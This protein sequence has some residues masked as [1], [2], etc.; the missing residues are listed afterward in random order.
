MKLTA[1]LK[2]SI[3]NNKFVYALLKKP[4]QYRFKKKTQ[5]KREAIQQYGLECLVLVKESFQKHQKEFWLDYGTLLGAIRE[6]DFIGHDLDADVGAFNMLEEEK[7][8][9]EGTLL[10]KGF[11]KL[12]EFVVNNIIVEQT[13]IYKDAHIDIFYYYREGN[14]KVWCYFFEDTEEMTTRI[15]GEKQIVT[16]WI[17][18]TAT[19]TYLGSTNILFKGEE[20]PIPSN[21]RQYLIENYGPNYMVKDENWDYANSGSNIKVV[22]LKN[23]EAIYE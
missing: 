13:Y 5:W 18:K 15:K 23:I 8:E 6:K 7:R 14:D 17:A 19:S 2:K 9:L 21:Y 1:K 16:G 20:F 12:R 4:L 22:S 11:T 3:K 10:S